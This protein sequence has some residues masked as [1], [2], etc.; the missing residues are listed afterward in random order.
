G[1]QERLALK[2]F[3]RTCNL[4]TEHKETK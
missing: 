2:K 3:C 1:Q 4:H